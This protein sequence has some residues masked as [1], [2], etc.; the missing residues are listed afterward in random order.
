MSCTLTR[1]TFPF[2][3]RAR[4]IKGICQSC[5]KHKYEVHGSKSDLIQD[6]DLIM[7]KTCMN[8]GYEPRHIIVLAARSGGIVKAKPFLVENRYLGDRILAS[9][10]LRSD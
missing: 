5:K 9:E 8:K 4:T 3:R 1:S 10:I 6:V 7:C 2:T